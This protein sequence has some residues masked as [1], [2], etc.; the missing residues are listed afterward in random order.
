ML[1]S[2]LQHQNTATRYR[3]CVTILQQP[4]SSGQIPIPIV[5]FHICPHAH[6][7]WFRAEQMLKKS[8]SS[9]AFYWCWRSLG[10][11]GAAMREHADRCDQPALA[12]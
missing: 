10:R 1:V 4:I 9:S 6:A 11:H 2:T 8:G 3:R 12:Y 5:H 7:W